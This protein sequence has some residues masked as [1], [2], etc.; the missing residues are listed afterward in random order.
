MAGESE[1][2]VTNP[3]EALSDEE[4]EREIQMLIPGKMPPAH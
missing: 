4:L 3:E 2:A 1:V